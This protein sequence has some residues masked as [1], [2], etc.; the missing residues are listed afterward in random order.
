MVR[1]I[2][3]LW[4]I[5]CVRFVA[6]CPL[7]VLHAVSALGTRIRFHKISYGGVGSRRIPAHPEATDT[8]FW[9]CDIFE[10]EGEQKFLGVVDEIKQACAAL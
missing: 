1:C 8:E 7:P 4:G 3:Q 9:D 6:C 5:N 10:D 2:R